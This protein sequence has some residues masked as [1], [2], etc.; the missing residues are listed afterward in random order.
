MMLPYLSATLLILLPAFA[1]AK[2]DLEDDVVPLLEAPEEKIY[3][4]DKAARLSFGGTVGVAYNDNIYRDDDN[5]ESDLI[6]VFSPGFRLKTDLKPYQVNIDG[7]LEVGE[8][9][10]EAENS[11]VDTDIRARV[12]YDITPDVNVYFGGRHQKEHVAIGAFTDTPNSQ[13]GEPTDYLYGELSGGVK[14]D[15]PSWVAHVDTGIDFYDYDNSR[16]RDGSLIINDDR[17]HDKAHLTARAGYKLEEDTILYVEGSYNDISYDNRVDSTALVQRDSNGFELLTGIRLGKHR[18]TPLFIDFGIG[19][20]QQEYDASALSGI[21]TLA[22]RSNIQWLPDDL[23]RVRGALTRDIR[24]TT[25]TGASA[26]VQTRIGGDA[27]YQLFDDL[28]VGGKLRFTQNDFEVSQAA[29]GSE[30]T[31]NIYDGG[32]FADYNFHDDYVVGGEYSYI[33]RESDNPGSD[34]ASNVFLLRLGVLY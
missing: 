34:Y 18:V 19:Y 17:D 27:S 29:G 10:L 31:D 28:K 32:I 2:D 22:I 21:S 11:Y 20:L 26:Y 16:R 30:R 9:L 7:R 25:T 12:G 6:S 1:V 23:W 8:Y 13:A 14:V 3:E 15:R 33:N 4:S 24:E 5:K